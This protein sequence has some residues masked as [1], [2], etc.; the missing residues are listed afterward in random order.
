MSVITLG[1]TD[2]FK[3]IYNNQKINNNK[4]RYVFTTKFPI[5]CLG[6]LTELFVSYDN[7]GINSIFCPHCQHKANYPNIVQFQYLR[8]IKERQL[9]LLNSFEPKELIENEPI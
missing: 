2:T 3:L 7:L 9:K 8:V 5:A 6:C 1:K 4:N